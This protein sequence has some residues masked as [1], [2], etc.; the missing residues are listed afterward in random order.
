MHTGLAVHAPPLVQKRVV[1]MLRSRAS[2]SGCLR[3]KQFQ[4]LPANS[5]GHF[6]FLSLVV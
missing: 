2:Y 6:S 1:D 4:R 5:A 3:K